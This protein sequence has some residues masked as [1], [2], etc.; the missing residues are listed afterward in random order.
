MTGCSVLYLLFYISEPDSLLLKEPVAELD[1][2]LGVSVLTENPGGSEWVFIVGVSVAPMVP[3]G[4][5]TEGWMVPVGL[6][7]A[8]EGL[9]ETKLSQSSSSSSS[10]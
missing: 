4:C 3:V 7:G 9:D 6:G 10:L 5:I 8:T 1:F 2:L